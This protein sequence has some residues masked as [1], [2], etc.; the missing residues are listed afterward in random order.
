V[1]PRPSP[2]AERVVA[3][4]EFLANHPDERFTL[5]EVAR[6]C[7]L[8]KATA[9]AL[10]T[11]LTGRGVLLRH[12]DEKRY[13]LGPRLVPIGDAAVQGYR[14]E[15]FAP[16]VLKRL[17]ATTGATSA[18]LLH[19]PVDDHADVVNQVVAGR[20]LPLP[21]HWPLVPPLGAVFFA[22]ADDPSAEAWLAR[23]PAGGSVQQAL[24]ALATV[25]R[26]RVMIGAAVPPWRQLT[27]LLRELH[28]A[29]VGISAPAVPEETEQEAVR[30]ALYELSRSRALVTDIVPDVTYEIAY[31]AAPVFD[32][33][34]TVRLAVMSGPRDDQPFVR[35]RAL[36]DLAAAVATAAD[37]LTAAVFGRRPW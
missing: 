23:C 11:E 29:T 19:D 26:D 15:D 25:R 5:S 4:L 32:H 34:G 1:A 8:N 31:V 20:S 30:H 22:W 17:A 12:P 10:L 37:E 27:A 28:P 7:H 35:G 9:H 21:T 18:A 36:R 16:T 33:T 24:E 3:V 2:G 6:E 14:I 13:S